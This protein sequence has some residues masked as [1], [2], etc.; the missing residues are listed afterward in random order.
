MRRILFLLTALILSVSIM[1]GCDLISSILGDNG[2]NQEGDCSCKECADDCSCGCHQ[3]TDG[4]G[5]GED[6]SGEDNPDDNDGE[7]T[8]ETTPIFE[9]TAEEWDAMTRELNYSVEIVHA[10]G[11]IGYQKYTEYAIELNGEIIIFVEDKQFNLTETATGWVAYDCTFINYGHGGLLKDAAFE[12]YFFDE[13]VS[14][15]VNKNYEEVG[16]RH[17]ISF[18]NGIV[19]ASITFLTDEESTVLSE[20][21][22][23]DIGSTVIDIPE[24]TFYYDL[25]ADPAKLVTEEQWNLCINEKNFAG[26]M[27]V[28]VDMDFYDCIFR[29]SDNAIEIDGEIIVTDSDTRYALKEIDGVWYAVEYDGIVIQE[30]SGLSFDNFEYDNQ[31]EMYVQKNCDGAEVCYSFAFENGILTYVQIER[32]WDPELS[33]YTEAIGIFITEIGTVTIDVPEFVIAE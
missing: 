8:P 31:Y 2:C 29:S 3:D 6:N 15:Y 33:Y 19:V 25:E 11:N 7:Q 4:N 27:S 24:F 1:V 17:E 16:M 32:A 22:F 18:E 20:L 9:V 12:D 28:F 5:N 23:T 13:S 26:E 14:A 10:Y 30:W 21:Y